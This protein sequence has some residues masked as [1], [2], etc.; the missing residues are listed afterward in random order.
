[1]LDLTN[2][3]DFYVD[4]TKPV[5]QKRTTRIDRPQETIQHK[6][7][8]NTHRALIRLLPRINEDCNKKKKA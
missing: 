6:T 3:S 7:K 1:M 5:I 8:C 4:P 2:P